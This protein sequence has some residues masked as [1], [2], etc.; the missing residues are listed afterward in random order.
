[1][2]LLSEY[3]KDFKLFPDQIVLKRLK[4]GVYFQGK[5]KQIPAKYLDYYVLEYTN[6]KSRK[7]VSFLLIERL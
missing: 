1:M 4:H 6:L 2:K 7:C 3:I 5:V